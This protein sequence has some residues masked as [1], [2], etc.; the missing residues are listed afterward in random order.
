MS[1]IIIS[2]PFSETV[3]DAMAALHQQ[4]FSRAWSRES[5]ASLRDK[6]GVMCLGVYDQEPSGDVE[7]EI[8]KNLLGYLLV[9]YVLD[10]A[11]ILT[12]V[13]APHMQNKGLGQSLLAA[14]LG[15][16]K[17]ED[18]TRFFLEVAADNASARRLYDSF[19]FVQTGLRAGYYS[20][21]DAILM[22]YKLG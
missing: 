18:M 8:E 7:T 2:T 16:A 3:L 15:W 13:V 17:T 5:F 4:G 6:K 10:E 20:G 9:Q 14:A 19:G 21:I 12:F 22:E 11:E 1:V